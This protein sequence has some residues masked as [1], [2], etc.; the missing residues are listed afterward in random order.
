MASASRLGGTVTMWL[1][2]VL[3]APSWATAGA[4]LALIAGEAIVFLA[5]A[6]T[7]RAGGRLGRVAGDSSD[8]LSSSTP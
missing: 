4:V 7:L 5:Q 6:I 3:L 1:L 2:L 8:Q